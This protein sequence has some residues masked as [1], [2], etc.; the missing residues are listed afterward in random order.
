MTHSSAIV[1][2]LEECFAVVF[3]DVPRKQLSQASV[4]SIAEWDSL[5]TLTLI[6]VIEESFGIKIPLEDLEEFVSF[7]LIADYIGRTNGEMR[8]AA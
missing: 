1:A 5:A 8:A 4:S 3:P 6:G 7:E 2:P